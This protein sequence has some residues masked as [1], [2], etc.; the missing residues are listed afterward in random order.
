MPLPNLISIKFTEQEKTDI[1]DALTVLENIINPKVINLT[2]TERQ[3][4]GRLGDETENFVVKTLTYT[5]QK[6]EIIPFFI[7]ANELKIDVESRDAVD[8][9]LKRLSIITEKLEDTHKVIGW[10]LYNAIIAVYRN[11]KMLSKQDVPGINVI[12]QDL[13]KQFPHYVPATDDTGNPV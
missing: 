7:E 13:K 2:P 5:Q 6:P 11:V 3:R 1:A 9:I 12:Y 8:P 10:D 4:Y